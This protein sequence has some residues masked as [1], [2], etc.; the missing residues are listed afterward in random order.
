MPSVKPR[1]IRQLLAYSRTDSNRLLANC[2]N[3]NLL[4][5]RSICPPKCHFCSYLV[6]QFMIFV[7]MG[8]LA[9]NSS[10]LWLMSVVIFI[11]KPQFCDH[12]DTVF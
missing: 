10:Y 11:V 9:V 6:L 8:V 5:L 3:G 1:S 7:N 12:F 4:L 2:V